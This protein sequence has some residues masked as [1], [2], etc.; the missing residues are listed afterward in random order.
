M[1][2]SNKETNFKKKSKGNLRY[3]INFWSVP[4]LP[5]LP[6]LF[7][8]LGLLRKHSETTNIQNTNNNNSYINYSVSGIKIA[9]L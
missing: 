5:A 3:Y 9:I 1:L 6:P 2:L 8:N 7:L 4:F